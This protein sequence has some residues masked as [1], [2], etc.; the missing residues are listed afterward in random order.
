MIIFCADLDPAGVGKLIELF[1]ER[2]LGHLRKVIRQDKANDAHP[3]LDRI[4]ERQ[5]KSFAGFSRIKGSR[6][7]SVSP[8]SS[9]R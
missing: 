5:L 4:R 9:I 8:C 3:I 1:Q 6:T 2:L 7:S